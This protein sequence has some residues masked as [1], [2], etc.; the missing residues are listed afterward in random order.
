LKQSQC[1][2]VEF[3]PVTKTK[4]VPTEEENVGKNMEESSL[5]SQR[6]MRSSIKKKTKKKK[7]V[8]EVQ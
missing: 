8:S 2:F 1:R 3:L 4:T 5:I 7:G 6:T